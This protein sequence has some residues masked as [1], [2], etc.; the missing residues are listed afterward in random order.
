MNY[1]KPVVL[2]GFVIPSVFLFSLLAGGLFARSWLDKEYDTRKT[3][4]E[5]LK[6]NE[7]KAVEMENRVLPYRG[8]VSYFSQLKEKR[9]SQTLPSL[10]ED[11]CNGRYQGYVI[12]TGLRIE[13]SSG[14][15][16]AQMEFLGRYDSLQKM[17]SELQVQYP[18]LKFSSGSFRPVDPTTSVPSK[19]L[20]VMFK[21]Y[22]DVE[23]DRDAEGGAR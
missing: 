3:A 11:F 22:N 10:L 23:P 1:F 13:E 14:K 15:E 8:A 19:H 7:E 12:R 21:A 4:F 9:I 2:L 6:E 18:F 5:D 16:E 17:M 20:S